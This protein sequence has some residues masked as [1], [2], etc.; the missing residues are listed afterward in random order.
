MPV[1]PKTPTCLCARVSDLPAGTPVPPVVAKLPCAGCGAQLFVSLSTR[2]AIGE[3]YM[4][5]AC[6]ECVPV[7]PHTVAV[8]SEDQWREC[9]RL[10]A[11]DA[12]RN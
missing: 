12:L 3:G 10:M 1:D 2:V 7:G 4:Q 9:K 5:P 6:R 8:L 11:E